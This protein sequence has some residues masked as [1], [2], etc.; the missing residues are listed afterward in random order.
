MAQV[1]KGGEGGGEAVRYAVTRSTG[2]VYT[3]VVRAR[4]REEAIALSNRAML[5]STCATC[6]GDGVV[7]SGVQ[8]QW[9]PNLRNTLVKGA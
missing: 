7:G 4:S 5:D 8:V 1:T 3:V 9:M 6:Q 2:Q